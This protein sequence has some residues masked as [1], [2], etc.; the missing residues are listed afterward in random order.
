MV[1]TKFALLG[2]Y[3]ASLKE[4][5]LLMSY[6]RLSLLHVFLTH[7]STADNSSSLVLTARKYCVNPK[8]EQFKMFVKNFR[9][10]FYL[11]H[12]WSDL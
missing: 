1:H 7:S 3:I 8:P 12:D 11:D 10:V 6:I 4:D 2:P 5:S 9:I